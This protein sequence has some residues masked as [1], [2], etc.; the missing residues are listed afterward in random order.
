MGAVVILR[1][2]FQVI[3]V[4]MALSAK[5]TIVNQSHAILKMVHVQRALTAVVGW[6]AGSRLNHGKEADAVIN[7][8]NK[9][10]EIAAAFNSAQ[11]YSHCKG[12][13]EIK[14]NT[15]NQIR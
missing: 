10:P 5:A 2:V 9:E 13:P 7:C 12:K 14:H 4:A 1:V 15:C 8:L 11:L 6:S 3:V